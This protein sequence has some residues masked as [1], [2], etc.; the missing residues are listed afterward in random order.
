MNTKRIA[1]F[2]VLLT[3]FGDVFCRRGGGFRGNRRI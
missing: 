1:I 3:L 2:V